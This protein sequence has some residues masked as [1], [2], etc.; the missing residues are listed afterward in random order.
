MYPYLLNLYISLANEP[1]F[2][3]TIH[4]VIIEKI[5]QTLCYEIQS[6]NHFLQVLTNSSSQGNIIPWTLCDMKAINIIAK[7]TFEEN[8]LVGPIVEKFG[9]PRS[10]LSKLLHDS[11][12]GIQNDSS[13]YNLLDDRYIL[14]SLSY[15]ISSLPSL[16]SSNHS[17]HSH[18]LSLIQ[19]LDSCLMASPLCLN[20]IFLVGL[21]SLCLLFW[22]GLSSSNVEHWIMNKIQ[23]MKESE[24]WDEE[25]IAVIS[26]YL[27]SALQHI[28]EEKDKAINKMDTDDERVLLRNKILIR[29]IKLLNISHSSSSSLHGNMTTTQVERLSLKSQNLIRTV[30]YRLRSIVD[31][32]IDPTFI[33]MLAIQG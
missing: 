16:S 25:W 3:S 6:L 18:F 8:T 27:P 32:D 24:E 23:N 7:L 1:I 30:L 11:F 21:G 17:S 33:C 2:A 9:G 4:S 22:G 20:K 19:L 15:F 14:S 28:P 13:L 5:V 10:L 12:S 31:I 26:I 29:M